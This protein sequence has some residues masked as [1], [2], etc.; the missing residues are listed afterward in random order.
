MSEL[1]PL[2]LRVCRL[3]GTGNDSGSPARLLVQQSQL[4]KTLSCLHCPD[5]LTKVGIQ[6]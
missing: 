1:C 2:L 5:D 3:G 4:A 6:V